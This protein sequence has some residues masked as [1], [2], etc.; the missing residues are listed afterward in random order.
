M[1]L[2]LV[3]FTSGLLLYVIPSAAAL[4]QHPLHISGLIASLTGACGISV[5]APL[6][7]RTSFNQQEW[8]MAKAFG[9]I[10]LLLVLIAVAMMNFSLAVFL[11]LALPTPAVLAQPCGI[12]YRHGIQ[13]T[14][15]LWRRY[16]SY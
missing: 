3:S 5:L 11:T 12:R 10:L 14:L 8:R 13:P 6:L 15:T 16:T 4:I 9:L 1:G 7:F 2:I